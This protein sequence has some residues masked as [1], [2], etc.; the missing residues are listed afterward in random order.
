MHFLRLFLSVLSTAP[1]VLSSPI[2]EQDLNERSL[3]ASACS[4]VVTIVEVLKLYKATPFCS[5]YLRISTSTST[6][7]TTKSTVSTI[8]TGTPLTTTVFAPGD[9]PALAARNEP[10]CN[11]PQLA[12]RNAVPLELDE[13][14]NVVPNYVS[15]FPTSAIS[16]ACSC[17]NLPTPS[18]V[19]TSTTTATIRTTVSA[20]TTTKTIYPCAAPLP[21]PG[22]AYGDAPSALPSTIPGTE[23]TRFYLDTPQGTSAQSCCNTCF[24]EVANCIQAFFYSYQGC[25]VQ[26][27]VGVIGTGQG[28][29]GSCPNGKIEG[30]VYGPDVMPAFRSTGNIV[31]PCGVAYNNV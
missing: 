25:V 20:P 6:A 30:L 5:S 9:P 19:T 27:G 7:T 16:S 13:R 3:S 23:N 12:N 17:L 22:P 10:E 2:L 29:S 26:Q 1:A 14:D 28:V 15:V 8:T 21:S 4:K 31:G 11:S 24:F 18:T